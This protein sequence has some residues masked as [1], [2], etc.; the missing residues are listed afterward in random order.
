LTSMLLTQ[1]T[2]VITRPFSFILGKILEGIFWFLG[3]FTD[4]PSAGAA[5][6]IMTVIIYLLLLPL[7]VKQQ[8]FSKLS[9]KMNPELQAIRNKY[10]GKTDQD[11]MMKMN[12]ETKLVYQKYGVNPSGSCIQLLIQL[13]ILWSL[14][15][16]IY[17]MPA[18]VGRIRNVFNPL[19]HNIVAGS[20]KETLTEFFKDFSGYAYYQKQFSND[21][22]GTA[23]AEG[24]NHT[25]NTIVD[26]LNRASTV[27]WEKVADKFPTL[28][29][30][31]ADTST[32][33]G[34]YN[35]FLGLNIGLTPSFVLK[36]EWASDTRNWALII[37]VLMIPVLS[38]LTQWINTKL[39]PQP[40]QSNKKAE[41]E[42]PMMSSMKTMNT[43]MPLMSA[44]FCFT[45]P[46]G[47]GIYWI[48]GSVVRS[49]IQVV[50]NKKLDKID[51]D[52]MIKN[53]VEKAN[54]KRRKNGLPVQQISSN[55]KINAKNVGS[56][57]VESETAKKARIDKN[58]KESTEYY[59]KNA[60]KP[61][62][63]AAKASMVKQY[64]ERNNSGK[65]SE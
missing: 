57:P 44:V 40:E 26:I 22:F 23:T 1:N 41:E 48:T 52:A 49:I 29:S 51:I 56:A 62:S 53:N 15:R 65:K 25:E 60:S 13:P 2:N 16:V 9:N 50:V 4:Y 36:S 27:E 61:G 24:I 6:I 14:Y 47:M 59:N 43:V 63:L 64:N 37:G 42:N 17:N 8:K 5:I 33:L 54:E 7:T 21:L 31:V 58:I 11:S 39:M 46:I 3:L 38:A 20:D 19:V 35:H 34:K 55:A 32:E 10:Q 28:A 12:E 30:Q 18:Y 45:L